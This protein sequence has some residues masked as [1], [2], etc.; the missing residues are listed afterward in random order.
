VASRNAALFGGLLFESCGGMIA[1]LSFDSASPI[2]VLPWA[3]LGAGLLADPKHR[4]AGLLLSAAALGLAANGGHPSLV[5]L[6]F[7]GF[8]LTL[9]G[10]TALPQTSDRLRSLLAGAAA[11]ALGLALGAPVLLPLVDLAGKAVSYKDTPMGAW[12]WDAARLQY[13]RT[14]PLALFVPWLMPLA[15]AQFVSAFPYAFA[16]ATGSIGLLCAMA[17]LQRRRL[18][19]PLLLLAL[20]GVLL[21]YAPPGFAWLHRLPLLRLILPGYYWPFLQLPLCVWAAAGFEELESS[22]PRTW[23]RAL[24]LTALAGALAFLLVADV[25]SVGLPARTVALRILSSRSGL[26][27]V[28]LPLGLLS[29]L[30]MAIGAGRRRSWRGPLLL[31][32]GAG[33]LL[34]LMSRLA[35]HP[36]PVTSDRTPN[37][38]IEF[39]LRES[40]LSH[41]RILESNAGSAG[42]PLW[43]GL[44]DLTSIAAL[45]LQRFAAFVSLS[46]HPAVSTVQTVSSPHLP[47]VDLASVRFVVVAARGAPAPVLDHDEA[48]A[49]V[50]SGPHVAIYENRSVLP[51]FRL[52]CRAIE[53]RD[54]A[55]AVS[56][57]KALSGQARHVE[58]TPLKEAVIVEPGPNGHYPAPVG[59]EGSPGRISTIRLDPDHIQ[60]QVEASADSYLV[61]S[62][63]F[64]VDWRAEIDSRAVPL[65]PADGAL[66]LIRVPAGT[67]RVELAYRP[68]AW[69]RG[70]ALASLALLVLAAIALGRSRAAKQPQP[71]RGHIEQ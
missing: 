46:A 4:R 43:F 22:S 8:G 42:V 17:G 25:P 60:L 15:R 11:A 5:A 27:H 52:A 53:A 7:L 48:F 69:P 37:P 57:L 21:A 16:M 34:L 38:E 45:P 66:R 54:L 2:C 59:C 32:A 24:G 33:E 29:A 68:R 41:T 10:A 36:A 63:L 1:Q 47:I 71:P 28:W 13:L 23:A 70:L 56:R 58:E 50:R 64:D 39:L 61:D 20:A 35:W 12:I 18:R 26:L 14:M 67:H 6:V 55:D 19:S 9:L 30:F 31:G 49:L 3:V 65:Y 62:D 51:R 44:S 40:R